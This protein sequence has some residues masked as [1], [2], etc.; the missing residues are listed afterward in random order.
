MANDIPDFNKDDLAEPRGPFTSAPFE[1]MLYQIVRLA[2]REEINAVSE[3]QLLT[4]K[5]AAEVLGFKNVRRVYDL[6]REKK[7]TAQRISKNTLRF[8]RS[9][10]QEYIANGTK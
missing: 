9:D 4:A 1:N 2:V 7:L 6:N 10:I 5:Q 8:R 3:D